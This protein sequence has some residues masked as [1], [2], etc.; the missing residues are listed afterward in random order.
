ML[1]TTLRPLNTM[2]HTIALN[3]VNSERYTL[4]RSR[5]HKGDFASSTP[6]NSKI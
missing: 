2:N 5:F 6:R 4:P 1:T 3:F